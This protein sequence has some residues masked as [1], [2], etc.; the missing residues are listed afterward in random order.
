M[1][2]PWGGTNLVTKYTSGSDNSAY[3][4]ENELYDTEANGEVWASGGGISQIWAKPSY[5][6]SVPTQSTKARTVPDLSQH[7]GGCPG[8]ATKCHT[9]HSADYEVL[10]GQAVGVIGTSASAPDIAGLFAL[11]VA[12]TGGRLGW[13]NVDIYTRAK[14]Q[15]AGT[16]KPFHQ[17]ITGNNGHYATTKP[18]NLVIGNGSVDARQLI[19]ATK[20]PAAG[21]PGTATNP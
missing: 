3:V 15:I 6:S 13:E 10:G 11:K 20:L 5:Q 16:G 4:S 1:W 21:V 9:P 14:A 2:W 8:D 12:M 18:Y 7:M 17:A 19:G